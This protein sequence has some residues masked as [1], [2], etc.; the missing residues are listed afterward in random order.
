MA[1]CLP[2]PGLWLGTMSLQ[3]TRGMVSSLLRLVSRPFLPPLRL[4]KMPWAARLFPLWQREEVWGTLRLQKW[5]LGRRRRLVG[6]GPMEPHWTLSQGHVSHFMA[7]VFW[8]LV[9]LLSL[10]LSKCNA[11]GVG[12]ASR[13][14]QGSWAPSL[15]LD[16][17]FPGPSGFPAASYVDH[18]SCI[19]I[20]Y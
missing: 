19:I 18:W 13:C 5:C 10:L 6:C 9:V 7:A 4:T 8:L 12:W 2:F 14:H 20:A 1:L 16:L 11:A 17:P 3:Q 15:T